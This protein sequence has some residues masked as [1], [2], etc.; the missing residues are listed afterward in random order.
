MEKGFSIP[1][2][3]LILALTLGAFFVGKNYGNV[4]L[5]KPTA[6]E[7]T[8]TETQEIK[9]AVQVKTEE[10]AD[11][12]VL[13][14]SDAGKNVSVGLGS[15]I[16]MKSAVGGFNQCRV[17]P[18][19]GVLEIP[20]GTGIYNFPMD[21]VALF[22][23][24]GAGT[25]DIICSV[26]SQTDETSNLKTFIS[27]FGYSLKYPNNLFIKD[28]TKES[29]VNKALEDQFINS[30]N[31]FSISN[32][33]DVE[34]IVVG[35]NIENIKRF[36]NY[37]DAGLFVRSEITT[38]QLLGREIIKAVSTHGQLSYPDGK[39]VVEGKSYSVLIPLGS[40]TLELY[41]DFKNKDLVE[42]VLSTFK[43]TD[44]SSNAGASRNL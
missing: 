44:Q 33:P 14:A 38:D 26:V 2:I 35:D 4:Q 23:A 41:A 30:V 12:I 40:N 28:M 15:I 42:K 36:L 5:P 32:K 22:K 34:V 24:V 20:S 29:K 19:T 1:V 39:E 9:F 25:A 11:T 43:F 16:Y 37:G 27:K 18:P 13:S 21:V 6:S 3:L 10:K 17:N 31:E 8:N 7:G